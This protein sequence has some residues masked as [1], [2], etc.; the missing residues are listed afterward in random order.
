MLTTVK[1][2]DVV[3]TDV[4]MRYILQ[5]SAVADE[6]ARRNRAVDVG[7]VAVVSAVSCFSVQIFTTLV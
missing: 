4:S 2:R 1:Y 7:F 6:P 5:V 3:V